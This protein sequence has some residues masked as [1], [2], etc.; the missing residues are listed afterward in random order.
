MIALTKRE[1][2]LASGLAVAVGAVALYASVI[3]PTAHRIETLERVIPEKQRELHAL[4]DK[5]VEYLALCKE[6]TDLRTKAAAQ[7]PNFQLLPYLEK[8]IDRH[9]LTRSV[10]T[11]APHV[12]D[13]QPDY[14]E[15]IVQIELEGVS[16]KQLV[17]LLEEIETSEV[18]TRIGS[19]HIR[20]DAADETLLDSAIEIHSPQ[21]R[22]SPM[23]AG[24]DRRP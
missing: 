23:A 20:K 24:A 18:C 11:I 10:T 8:L 2:V 9:G 5:S 12:V 13:L 16:L 3:R 4:E 15:T 6:Y 19:L 22:R 1:R 7:D 17:G 21:P 14:S